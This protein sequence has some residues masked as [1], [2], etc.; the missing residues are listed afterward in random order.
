M[1]H[2]LAS[3]MFE[4]M[5]HKHSHEQLEEWRAVGRSV[6]SCVQVH[7][8]LFLTM[9]AH[10]SPSKE[11]MYA[12]AACLSEW[13]S[14]HEAQLTSHLTPSDHERVRFISHNVCCISHPAGL[15]VNTPQTTP[16]PV[17]PF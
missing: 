10:A 7:I 16:R 1:A 15:T 4:S 5:G 9:Q 11:R 3:Q 8:V 13:D 14:L 2:S 6:T 12:G 17:L